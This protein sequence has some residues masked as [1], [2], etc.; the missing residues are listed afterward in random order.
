M[1]LGGLFEEGPFLYIGWILLLGLITS[2]VFAIINKREKKG[3]E[4]EDL[5]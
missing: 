5:S 1:N 3:N 2:L 4:R